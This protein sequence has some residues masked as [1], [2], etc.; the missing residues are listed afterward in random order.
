MLPDGVDGAL[1]VDPVAAAIGLAAIVATLV[2]YRR[3]LARPRLA[4]EIRTTPLVTLRREARGVLQV[5]LD[6]RPVHDVYLLEV[7]FANTGSAAIRKEDFDEPLR[8]SVGEGAKPISEVTT[9]SGPL[10]LEPEV[11][12][13]GAALIVKP[14]LLNP[15]DSFWLKAMIQDF[16]GTA[17]LEPPRITDL[18]RVVDN[19]ARMSGEQPKLFGH[20][21]FF[22]EL[23]TGLGVLV[24]A[25]VVI[26]V[27][28]LLLSLID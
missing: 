25:P 10:G 14:L 13:A 28:L 21:S 12:F 7:R 22:N 5:T 3:Q 11:D 26:V 20:D 16:N 18:T 27:L 2:I 9:D 1:S 24:A 6:G 8:L 4:Y 17:A 15:G 23:A 19:S